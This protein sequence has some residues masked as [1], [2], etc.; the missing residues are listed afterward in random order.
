MASLILQL[1]PIYKALQYMNEHEDLAQLHQ[2]WAD[3]CGKLEWK[4][5]VL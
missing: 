2:T 3:I 4:M 1:V 5:T